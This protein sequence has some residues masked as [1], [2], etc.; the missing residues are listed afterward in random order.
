VRLRRNVCHVA[1]WQTGPK[2]S[3]ETGD[4]ETG[5]EF[6]VFRPPRWNYEGRMWD[7][8][9]CFRAENSSKM[10]PQTRFSIVAGL[11]ISWLSGQESCDG[12]AF[13]QRSSSLCGARVGRRANRTSHSALHL[14][15]QAS[16]FLASA[17]RRRVTPIRHGDRNGGGTPGSVAEG[18]WFV[19]LARLHCIAA[20]SRR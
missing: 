20:R 2:T 3:P 18:H 8:L 13:V 6:V 7:K 4:R 1:T 11:A 9:A 12:P 19:L 17:T 14:V 10:D 16:R 5:T 15:A